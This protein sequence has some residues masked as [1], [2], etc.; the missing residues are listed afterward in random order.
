MLPEVEYRRILL[1]LVWF[2]DNDTSEYIWTWLEPLFEM[3]LV[4]K[5]MDKFITDAS[6]KFEFF[7]KR[8]EV[9]I[10]LE[11]GYGSGGR[12]WGLETPRST[13]PTPNLDACPQPMRFGL[14]NRINGSYR[15]QCRIPDINSP[16]LM[17]DIVDSKRDRRQYYIDG[18]PIGVLPIPPWE[19]NRS[20]Q[21]GVTEEEREYFC[22]DYERKHIAS[23][24]GDLDKFVRYTMDQ[25]ELKLIS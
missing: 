9:D 2:L 16:Y 3:R 13:A 23:I 15:L 10:S 21:L 11:I 25:E 18:I 12:R 19:Q 1:T 8:A 22:D 24:R 4:K 7:C 6:K 20:Y 14:K 17:W 5:D